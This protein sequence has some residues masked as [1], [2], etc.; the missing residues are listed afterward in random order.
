MAPKK[1]NIKIKRS[2]FNL[3]NKK[4]SKAKRALRVVITVLAVCA[5]GVLGYGL[6]KPLIK[7]LQDRNSGKPDTSALLSSMIGDVSGSGAVSEGAGSTGETSDPAPVQQMNDKIYY[8]PEN[9]ALSET[10]LSSALSAAKSS[11]CSVVAVTLKNADGNML[12][13]TSIAEIKDSE[14]VVTGT[15]TASQIASMISKEGFTPA[16]RINTLM[17]KTG[18]GIVKGNYRIVDDQGGGTWHDDRVEKGGKAWLSPFKSESISYIGNITSELSAAGFKRIICLNTRF[19]AF[20]TIDISTYLKD[21]P[22]TDNSKRLSALWNVVS[23]AKSGAEKNGA[24]IWL[25]ISGTSLIAENQANTDAEL[26][27][28]KSRLGNVKII[29]NYDLLNQ[30]A[31]SSGNTTSG[32]ASNTSGATSSSSA[33]NSSETSTASVSRTALASN[34]SGTSSTSGASNT[35][36]TSAASGSSNKNTAVDN[37][38]AAKDFAA[39]AK[40]A[41]GSTEF[42]VRLPETIT[43]KALEDI[44]RALNEAGIT[45]I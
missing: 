43:G 37:Y 4:K 32:S 44:T 14:E 15:L 45:I 22:L 25:E 16:A 24:E 33:S 21:L 40:A 38:T 8:L 28:D 30:T 9:A 36:N 5:L 2:K 6:G 19:P 35:S 41:L 39:K 10:A 18:G 17:D 3:Y 29:V 26:I 42:G 34:T 7:Y 13:K 27:A 12:Y 20:H 31:S 1:T 23:S 11:G